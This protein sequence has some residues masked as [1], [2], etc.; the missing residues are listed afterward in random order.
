M[1]R[2]NDI[3]ERVNSYLYIQ[4]PELELIKSAYVYSAKV[5][6]GQKRS[7]GEPYLSHPLEVVAILADMKLDVSSIITGFLHDTV[8]DT[9]ATLEEIESLFGKEIALLVDGV[10][11]ISQLPFSS[12]VDE[13]A[14]SFRKLILA[15]AKD[16]RVVLIKLADRL[17]NMRTLQHLSEDKRKRIAKETFEIYSPLAHRLGIDWVRTELDDLSF[18]FL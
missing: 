8:E 18:R 14:E 10:T 6:T 16:I 5:H 1:I 11:K 12:K 4:E 2:L 15:T 9:L 17:H 13:Q 7:S 3:I